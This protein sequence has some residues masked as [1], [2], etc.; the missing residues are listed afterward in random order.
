MLLIRKGYSMSSSVERPSGRQAS[1]KGRLATAALPASGVA[2]V[3]LM[4]VGNTLAEEGGNPVLGVSLELLGLAALACFVAY[5]ATLGAHRVWARNLAL[6]AGITT[7]AVK[8][9]SAAPYLAVERGVLGQEV[10]A[11]LIA[12]NDAAFVVSWF[13]HGLLVIGLAIAALQAARLPRAVSWLGVVIGV[14]CMA[15]VAIPTAEP[16][17]IPFLLS[18]LWIIAASI[19]LARDELRGAASRAATAA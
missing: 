11:G 1:G 9:A 14:G 17:V 7:L 18:L 5:I 2:F 3:V 16:F 8:L 13:P 6:V 10:A 4:L 15:A 19:L 12:I